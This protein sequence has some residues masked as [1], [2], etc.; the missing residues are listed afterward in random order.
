MQVKRIQ[1]NQNTSFNAALIRGQAPLGRK[2]E[3]IFYAL[4]DIVESGDFDAKLFQYDTPN[5]IK[6]LG[7]RLIT[8]DGFTEAFNMP[9]EKANTNAFTEGYKNLIAAYNKYN[10]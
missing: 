4:G 5:N 7:L 9:I 10:K 2:A 3:K 1:Q 8:K 6:K